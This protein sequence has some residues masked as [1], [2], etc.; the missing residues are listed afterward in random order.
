[1]VARIV[2]TAVSL[3]ARLA[4]PSIM[5]AQNAKAPTME[6]ILQ[7]LDTNLSQYDTH[8]PSLFCDERVLSQIKPGPRNRNLVT[9]SVFRL[10]RT[11]NSDQTTSLEESRDIKKVGGKTGT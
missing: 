4:L 1:M 8:V 2:W 6:E 3:M 11:L 5:C 7:R 9:D 10:K